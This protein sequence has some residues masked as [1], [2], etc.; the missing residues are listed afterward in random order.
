MLIAKVQILLARWSLN[1]SGSLIR[2]ADVFYVILLGLYIF[3]AHIQTLRWF[4]E[5]KYDI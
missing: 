3:K 4:T 2:L 5:Y 1:R